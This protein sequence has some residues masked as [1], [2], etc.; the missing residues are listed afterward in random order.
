MNELEISVIPKYYKN[1]KLSFFARYVDDIIMLVKK[2]CYDE[3]LKEFNNY[4]KNLKFTVEKMNE[5]KI[6]SLYITF[7]LR[8]SKLHMWNYCK[9]QSRNKITDLIHEICPRSQKIG[10]LMAEIYRV[11]NTTNTSE[12]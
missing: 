4:S 9:P 7:E 2:D 6:N 8:D 12:T 1:K 5:N 10:T 3:I 11:N